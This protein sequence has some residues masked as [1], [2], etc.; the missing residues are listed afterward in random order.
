MSSRNKIMDDV[1][2]LS[3][4]VNQI[5]IGLTGSEERNC[6]SLLGRCENFQ[7]DLCVVGRYTLRAAKLELTRLRRAASHFRRHERAALNHCH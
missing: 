7:N 3:R 5:A 2:Q 1:Y 6:Y 4:F